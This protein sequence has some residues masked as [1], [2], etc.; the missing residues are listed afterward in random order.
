MDASMFSRWQRP[1]VR[2]PFDEETMRRDVDYYRSL[3]IGSVTSFA[4]YLDDAYVQR[5]GMP[6][7]EAYADT[8]R[9]LA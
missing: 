2:L 6:P 5:H 3:G 1:A 8:L 9:R 7:V 4:C